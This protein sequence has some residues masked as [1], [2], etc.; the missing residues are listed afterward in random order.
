MFENI[1]LFSSLSETEISTLE[2]F[3]QEKIVEPWELLFS[4]WEDATAMYILK[5]WLLEVYNYEKTLWYIHP[6]NFFW[7][8]AIFSAHKTRTAFV[9]VIEK[10]EIISLLLFS[11]NEL[12]L[13]HPDIVKKIKQVIEER[14]LQ[15]G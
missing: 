4:L 13:K 11:I 7:E 6:G 3:C 1:E 10:S 12:S 5:S 14:K 9:K 2:M 15:N 8:M